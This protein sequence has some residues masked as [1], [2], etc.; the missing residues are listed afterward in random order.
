MA[1]YNS[2]FTGAHNDEYNTRLTALEALVPA[3][4]NTINSVKLSKGMEN[5]VMTGNLVLRSMNLRNTT[6][7]EDKWGQTGVSFQA[8]DG[9]PFGRIE[10]YSTPSSR[11]GIKIYGR[12][13]NCTQDLSLYLLQYDN[14]D[15]NVYTNDT[16]AWC[17]GICPWGTSTTITD[18][19]TANSAVTITAANWKRWGR[20]ANLAINFKNVNAIT[21]VPANGNITNVTVGTLKA[22]YRPLWVTA[23]T[24]NGDGQGP[25]FYTISNNG[26]ITLCVCAGTGASRTIA[27]DTVFT[28]RVT[29]IVPY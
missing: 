28:L 8:N 11:K 9:S 14:G 1:V 3:H 27:A 21:N 2:K 15:F 12:N 26:T 13:A 10:A 5:D 29:Y 19:I 4:Y 23:A 25:C 16:E 6:P 7:T 22:G 18:I 17:T 24:S 20:I